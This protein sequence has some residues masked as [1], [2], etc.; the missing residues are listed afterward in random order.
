MVPNKPIQSTREY[1]Y[2]EK[3]KQKEK[4]RQSW[5]P[6]LSHPLPRSNPRSLFHNLGINPQYRFCLLEPY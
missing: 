2:E 1:S 4:K 3:E 6:S 5:K